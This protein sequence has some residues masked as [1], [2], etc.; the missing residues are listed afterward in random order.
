M[1]FYFS[2]KTQKRIKIA[3]VSIVALILLSVG[4]CEMIEYITKDMFK[5]SPGEQYTNPNCM[6]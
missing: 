2:Q 1:P 4:G 3:L 6:Q 5:C